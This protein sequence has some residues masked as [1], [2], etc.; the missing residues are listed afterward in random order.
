MHHEK[1]TFATL[2]QQPVQDEVCT[3][4]CRHFRQD[5]NRIPEDFLPHGRAVLLVVGTVADEV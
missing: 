2:L 4:Y 1:M 3:L 5:D